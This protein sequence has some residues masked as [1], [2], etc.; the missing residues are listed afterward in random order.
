MLELLQIPINS[1]T[2]AVNTLVQP[3]SKMLGYFVHVSSL[4]FHSNPLINAI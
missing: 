1:V 3:L 4:V 2:D